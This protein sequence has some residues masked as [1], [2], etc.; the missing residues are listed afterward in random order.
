MTRSAYPTPEDACPAPVSPYGVTKLTCEHLFRAHSRNFG[1]DYV[2]LRYF[3]VY[4]PRQRP[5][6]AFARL[7]GT[8]WLAGTASRS[9]GDGRQ[10]RDFTF[11]QDAVAA[12]ILAM[13]KGARG[14]STTSVAEARR[15]S[16]SRSRSWRS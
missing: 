7:V 13:R 5:D 10:S 8:R 2:A 4:G 11:V 6:M 14:R 3:T 9:I 16:G 15:R 1:L 12:T